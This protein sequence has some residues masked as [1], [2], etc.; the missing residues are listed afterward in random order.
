MVDDDEVPL[1]LPTPSRVA[2][3]AHAL[4][5]QAYRSFLEGAA[6]DPKAASE[7]ARCL[8]WCERVGLR[9]ELEPWEWEI[10]S[11][12]LGALSPREA[13]NAG[14]C[15][16]A[17]A[18][19]AWALGR[20]EI[21]DYEEQQDGAAIAQ[22]MGFLDAEAVDLPA[23]VRLRP[24]DELEHCLSIYLALHWRLRDFSLRPEPLDFA[25]FVRGCTWGDLSIDGLRLV[26]GDL[27][28]G[29]VPLSK[30]TEAA[31]RTCASIA[32]ERHRAAEW[33][34]GQHPL[35]SEVTADT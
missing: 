34:L 6:D 13:V 1:S 22:A 30:A 23:D 18:L 28:I 19:L 10:L 33:L 35:Y 4:L 31:Y 21:L 9:R 14:W 32:S 5:T 7:Q 2:A 12:P 29:G 20:I 11:R 15:L 3:R 26:D 27:S 16:E 25:A 8:A 24:R 17:A